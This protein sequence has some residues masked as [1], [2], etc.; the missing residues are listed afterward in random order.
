MIL[1]MIHTLLYLYKYIY[2][3]TNLCTNTVLRSLKTIRYIIKE[4]L[5]K[6]DAQASNKL[7]NLKA[8]LKNMVFFK[9]IYF[10][11]R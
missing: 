11:S 1:D 9:K 4:Q 3:Y 8:G 5:K 6:H 7:S 10:L 2:F